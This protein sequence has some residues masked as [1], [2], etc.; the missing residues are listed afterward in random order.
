MALKGSDDEALFGETSDEDLE[1]PRAVVKPSPIKALPRDKPI[2]VEDF[3]EYVKAK[4]YGAPNHELK[5]DSTV[6][7][8]NIFFQDT[9]VMFCYVY[10]REESLFVRTDR[11]C[12][13]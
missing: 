7:K 9:A 12:H 2:P 5:L 10:S 1:K 13:V 11:D 4:K 8:V 3:I 6:M